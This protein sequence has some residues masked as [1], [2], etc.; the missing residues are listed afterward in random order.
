MGAGEIEYLHFDILG[1]DE[2]A[3]HQSTTHII[4]KPG[5]V[6]HREPEIIDGEFL[7][8]LELIRIFHPDCLTEDL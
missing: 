2:I 7:G 6:N 1:K 5:I 3:H 4:G 8:D